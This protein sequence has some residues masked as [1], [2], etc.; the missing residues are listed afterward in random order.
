MA[1]LNL[2]LKGF[3]LT[4]ALI[5]YR[6]PDYP[7]LLQEYLWQNFDKAPRFPVLEKFLGFWENNLD[8]KLYAVEVCS[9]ELIQPARFQHIEHDVRLH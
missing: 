5:T 9:A 1:S 6:L 2:Q 3:R 4:T 8:G 7:A